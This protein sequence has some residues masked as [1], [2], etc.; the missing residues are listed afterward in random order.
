MKLLTTLRRCSLFGG[1][2]GTE[3]VQMVSSAAPR[4][5]W[6]LAAEGGVLGVEAAC[7]SMSQRCCG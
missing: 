2:G 6:L 1:I 7:S 4:R 3:M 5:P